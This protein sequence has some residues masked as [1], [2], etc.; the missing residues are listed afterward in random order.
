LIEPAP[1]ATVGPGLDAPRVTVLIPSWNAA[2][3]IERAIASVLDAAPVALECVVVD[4][5]ST[6]GTADVVEAI[7]RGDQRVRLLRLQENLGVSNARNRGLTL[8]RGEWL[9][10]LDAD[11]RLLPGAIDALVRPTSDPDV[12]AVIGQRIWTDGARIWLTPVYDNPDVRQPG[13]K[14]IATHPGLLYYASSTG[15]LIHR[16]LLDGLAFE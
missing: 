15:K 13:R 2:S 10:F 5:G 6:D 7:G 11:D 8:A 3:T 1:S 4:D 12:L 14:S 9:A 16:S